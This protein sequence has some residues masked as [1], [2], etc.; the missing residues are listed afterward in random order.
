[1]PE[2]NASIT[3]GPLVLGSPQTGG[4]IGSTLALLGNTIEAGSGENLVVGNFLS[5]LPN[6][7]FSIAGEV[8]GGGRFAIIGS[9]LVT[10]N[11]PTGAETDY[12]IKARADS[13]D[14]SQA[15]EKSFTVTTSPA[16]GG[17]PYLDTEAP[18]YSP[19]AIIGEPVPGGT[20]GYDIGTW[21]NEVDS[22]K[23]WV[24]DGDSLSDNILLGP[25]DPDV[26]SSGTISGVEGK[27]LWLYVEA[28]GP[29]GTTGAWSAVGFGPIEGVDAEIIAHVGGVNSGSTSSAQTRSVS[30]NIPNEANRI[31]YAFVS[32][33]TAAS[34]STDAGAI[35]GVT[36]A[37]T[38]MTLIKLF[39]RLGPNTTRSVQV[40]VYGAL[41]ASIPASS[42]VSVV[43]S[44]DAGGIGSI[45]GL[46]VA[47]LKN[48]PQTLVADTDLQQYYSGT[49]VA[50]YSNDHTL[51]A[52]V[53]AL[54]SMAQL[55]NVATADSVTHATGQ[56]ALTGLIKPNTQM[57]ALSFRE[58]G[59][60]GS[61]TFSH[62]F[63]ELNRFGQWVICPVPRN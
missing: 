27:T 53:I 30:L 41:H 36:I 7:V 28:T 39:D 60:G 59:A 35:T 51:P 5:N 44:A 40:A 55:S 37:G 15:V 32:S 61:R 63:T 45:L 48:A 17:A 16:L 54:C 52:D 18:D 22:Y 56:T 46:T 13:G 11:V 33:T 34:P 21:S 9:S 4:S 6:P 10:T 1:M 49:S 50:S 3:L 26:T 29:G 14:S 38:P 2:A 23:F 19:V 57:A 43:A 42:S 62:T 31:A 58:E 47:V 20:W 8:D 12:T 24:Y 25:I